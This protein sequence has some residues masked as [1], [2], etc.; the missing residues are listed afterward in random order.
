MWLAVG[1][2]ATFWDS[3]ATIFLTLTESMRSRFCSFVLAASNFWIAEPTVSFDQSIGGSLILFVFE[4]FML[5][6]LT[7][8][9]GS[10]SKA[11]PDSN[12]VFLALLTPP[13]FRLNPMKR[14]AATGIIAKVRGPGRRDPALIQRDG[15]IDQSD[16]KIQ[17]LSLQVQ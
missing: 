2:G 7:K 10:D 14:I 17:F 15:I 4:L 13:Y 5:R 8:E 12:T 16:I 9:L 3:C 6:E 1:I 11:T